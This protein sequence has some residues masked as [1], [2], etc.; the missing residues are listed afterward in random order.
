MKTVICSHGFGVDA[1]DRGLFTDIAAAFPGYRFIMFDYNI[2]DAVGNMTVRTLAQQT[3][4]LI[5]KIAEADG[6]VML[7]CHSQGCITAAL[8]DLTGV[9]SMVWLTPPDNLDIPRFVGIFGSRAGANFNPDGVSS[10]PRRDGTVTYIGKDYLESIGKVDALG[11]YTKAAA[12]CPTTLIRA[13]N[14]EIVGETEFPGVPASVLTL[15]GT[16]DFSGQARA[17]LIKKLKGILEE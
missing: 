10:I 9:T 6:E 16:H 7:L 17:G 4:M 13:T 8:A 11:A 5:E 1:T 12:Q 14:D 15:S 3:E 2:V